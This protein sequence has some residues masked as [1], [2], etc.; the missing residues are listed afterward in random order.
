MMLILTYHIIRAVHAPVSSD[1]YTIS[2]TQLQRQLA[3]LRQAGRKCLEPAALLDKKNSDKNFLL[4]FD[5]GSIDHLEIVAPILERNDCRAIFFIPTS[6]LDRAGYLNKAQVR[7][8]SEQ[9]HSIGVHSHEHRRMDQSSDSEIREQ[10]KKSSGLLEEITGRL[11]PFF[12]P[13]GGYFNSRVQSVALGLGFKIIRTM[14]WGYNKRIDL[15][16]LETI[17]VNRTMTEKKFQKILEFKNNGWLYAGKEGL[18]TILPMQ[19]YVRLRNAVLRG[20]S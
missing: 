12:A 8:L 2:E 20:K 1:F 19:G 18:K 16:A 6:K 13:P 15:T 5:D 11:S 3:A 9:G 17:P 14:K 10:L 4:T 7:T